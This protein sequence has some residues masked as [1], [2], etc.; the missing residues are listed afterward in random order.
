MVALIN[1]PLRE[2]IL[3]PKSAVTHEKDEDRCYGRCLRPKEDLQ[4]L[5]C[6]HQRLVE[7]YR[8]RLMEVPWTIPPNCWC[9][10]CCVAAQ[11]S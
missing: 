3:G 8:L 5:G 9:R 6:H 7:R 4:K 2:S 1:L 11:S 10:G